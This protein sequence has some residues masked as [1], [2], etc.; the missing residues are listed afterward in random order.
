[1]PGYQEFFNQNN[2]KPTG[3]GQQFF[4]VTLADGQAPF[5]GDAR[6]VAENVLPSMNGLFMSRSGHQLGFQVAV[7]ERK[8][9]AAVVW[10]DPDNQQLHPVLMTDGRHVVASDPCFIPL[11][12]DGL[13]LGINDHRSQVSEFVPELPWLAD[14]QRLLE[15]TFSGKLNRGS[16]ITVEKMR[17]RLERKLNF[18]AVKSRRQFF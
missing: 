17:D 8:N 1:M 6:A 15:K 18:G 10:A 11:G 4:W 5:S 9:V 12:R 3:E 7:D 14:A 16:V 13:C 2:G